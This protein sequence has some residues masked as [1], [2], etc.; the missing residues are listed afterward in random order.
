MGWR[1]WACLLLISESE[2]ELWF[3][4]S[5]RYLSSRKSWVVVDAFLAGSTCI[6][7][8]FHIIKERK[9]GGNRIWEEQW[10]KLHTCVLHM[11]F[12][13]FVKLERQRVLD[14]QELQQPNTPESLIG[15]TAHTEFQ[16]LGSANRNQVSKEKEVRVHLWSQFELSFKFGN[17]LWTKTRFLERKHSPQTTKQRLHT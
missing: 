1:L 15:A 5:W 16:N 4:N 11:S 8:I 7:P 3:Q 14:R 2:H 17:L 13:L 9:E 6:F 12:P 10:S